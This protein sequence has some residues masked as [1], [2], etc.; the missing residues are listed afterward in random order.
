M[1]IKNEVRLAQEEIVLLKSQI[2]QVEEDSR[3]VKEEIRH[4]EEDSRLVKE[5][6]RKIKND[7][8]LSEEANRRLMADI[9][10]VEEDSR[11]VKTRNRQLEH[12]ETQ[13]QE[14]IKT[15]LTRIAELERE[16][17]Q[18]QEMTNNTAGEKRLVEEQL[19]VIKEEASKLLV[20][21]SALLSEKDRQAQHL[22]SI[23][24]EKNKIAETNRRMEEEHEKCKRNISE[25]STRVT[26]AKDC[27]ELYCRG[28]RLDGVYFIK[29]DR[30]GRRVSARCDM[31]TDGGGWT[32]FVQRDTKV[33]PAVNF[34]R[35]WE[36]Y[37]TGFGNASTEYWLGTE[38]VHQLTQPSP[39]TVRLAA[40]NN[41]DD[42]RWALWSTFSVAGENTGYELLVA[43]YQEESTMGDV[44][45]R[46]YNFS[47]TK[48]STIDRDNDLRSGGSCAQLASHQCGWWFSDCSYVFP[49]SLRRNMATWYW[50]PG[51]RGSS[52]VGLQQIHMM[53]RP[54]NFPTCHE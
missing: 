36:A 50:A 17:Q 5:E 4:V 49:T 13:T 22:R 14:R 20:G 26:M 29:P 12:A 54:Q 31:T 18:L 46:H 2:R 48:F 38:A 25:L 10:Q 9:N 52:G 33:V 21:N 7:V 3:L 30:E 53:T 45:V 44:L 16:T 51:V 35:D 34:T 27:A 43:G 32:V 23:Q 1:M 8:R 39:Q 6:N 40:T 28:V 47:G 42:H 37:K 19:S 15:A 11:L 24:E 41:Q